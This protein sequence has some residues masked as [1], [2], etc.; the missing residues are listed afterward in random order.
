MQNIEADSELS[1]LDLDQL[2]I[3]CEWHDGQVFGQRRPPMP[4]KL[5]RHQMKR[6]PLELR[7]ET[8]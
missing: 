2:L 3:N 1:I 6:E 5:E 7:C 4:K 8:I